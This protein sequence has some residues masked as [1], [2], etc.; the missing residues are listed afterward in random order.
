MFRYTLSFKMSNIA[1]FDKSPEITP[2]SPSVCIAFPPVLTKKSQFLLLK[3]TSLLVILHN[4]IQ[5]DTGRLFTLRADIACAAFKLNTLLLKCLRRTCGIFDPS[6]VVPNLAQ[7]LSTSKIPPHF[8]LKPCNFLKRLGS[9]VNSGWLSFEVQSK[10]LE[11]SSSQP[12][13][14]P[15]LLCFHQDF[16]HSRTRLFLTSIFGTSL[17]YVL[18]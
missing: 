4:H 11:E 8:T 16:R 18:Q 5:P 2:K 6:L 3:I 13:W 1:Q 15:Q 7:C 17:A 10:F 14:T 12:L 9:D